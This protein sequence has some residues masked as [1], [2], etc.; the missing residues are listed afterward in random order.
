MWN[1][2]FRKKNSPAAQVAEEVKVNGSRLL[3]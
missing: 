2:M 1:L 3:L